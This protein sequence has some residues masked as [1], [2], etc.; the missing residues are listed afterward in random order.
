MPTLQRKVRKRRDQPILVSD[1]V[2]APA[3]RRRFPWRIVGLALSSLGLAALVLVAVF[4]LGRAPEDSL[5]KKVI[6]PPKPD[7]IDQPIERLRLTPEQLD[8]KLQL[9]DTD[10][11]L[12]HYAEAERSYRE[13]VES[14]PVK[15]PVNFRI[16]ACIALAGRPDE[17]RK[18]IMGTDGS[19]PSPVMLYTDALLFFQEGRLEKARERLTQAR[20]AF[21]EQCGSYDLTLRAVG[22]KP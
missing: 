7:R 15:D 18:F 12:K 14:A 21:P 3:P 16:A 22:Y 13:I 5:Y 6:R 9:A 1:S 4:S 8:L 2:L 20:E 11:R 17:A 19:V 10:F